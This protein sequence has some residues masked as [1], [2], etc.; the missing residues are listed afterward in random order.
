MATKVRDVILGKGFVYVK[1]EKKPK[2]IDSIN[3]F[4]DKLGSKDK[5]PAKREMRQLKKKLPGIYDSFDWTRLAKGQCF[6]VIGKDAI[7]LILAQTHITKFRQ[8][9][10]L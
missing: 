9:K 7:H 6:M 4:L 8:L 5:A 1:I 10:G 3:K 2:S